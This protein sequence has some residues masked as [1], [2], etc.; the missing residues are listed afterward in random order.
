M[1]QLLNLD[2]YSES[3]ERVIV[4]KGMRHEV[5]DFTVRESMQFQKLWVDV[6]DALEKDDNDR[7]I[8]GAEAVVKFG[9]PTMTDEIIATL[10]PAQLFAAMQMV[11][12]FVPRP[13]QSAETIAVTGDTGA[14]ETSETAENQAGN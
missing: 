9:C 14:A 2:E 6:T 3:I 5:K 4:L 1:T 12:G 13:P 11:G 8:A 10:K 7:L